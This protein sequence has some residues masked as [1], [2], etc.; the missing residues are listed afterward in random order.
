MATHGMRRALYQAFATDPQVKL[1][2]VPAMREHSPAYLGALEG[3]QF[4]WAASGT[5]K[6]QG[7][8][9]DL[10]VSGT[11]I[12]GDQDP[13]DALHAL[14]RALWRYQGALRLLA[15]SEGQEA[16]TVLPE[17]AQ[18]VLP[19]ETG[20]AIYERRLRPAMDRGHNRSLFLIGEPG[21]GKSCM[22]RYLGELHGGLQLRF[23][24]ADM[25]RLTGSQIANV[26]EILRPDVLLIDDF[27]RYVSDHDTGTGAQMLDPL[28]TIN[29]LVKL[30]VVSANFNERITHAL[31]RPGRFDEIIV[32][33]CLE[34]ALYEKLLPGAPAKLIQAIQREKLPMSHVVELAKRAEALDGD[35][36]AAERDLVELAK[37]ADRVISLNKKKTKKKGKSTRLKLAGKSQRQKADMLE[38]RAAKLERNASQSETW[39]AKG[40]ATAEKHREEAKV[41]REK[42]VK[43]EAKA[44]A[45]TTTTKKKKSRKRTKAKTA[46]KKRATA[47][48]P[49]REKKTEA[50]TSPGTFRP[51]G[52]LREERGRMRTVRVAR[53]RRK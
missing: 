42:A 13:G 24:L 41:W 35:W 52:D 43:A 27:D 29:R 10:E 45:K 34:P 25:S 14:G 7:G 50:T 53:R 3:I 51:V 6:K 12:R 9:G 22:L 36:K 21:V 46:K 17:P 44:K 19:S 26:V 18:D 32:V 30:F 38:R 11:W 5:P 2:A 4:G 49:P 16:L 20:R 40:R 47:E 37:R 48:S 28:E 39:A 15:R 33:E 23:K 8:G 31:L 1:E